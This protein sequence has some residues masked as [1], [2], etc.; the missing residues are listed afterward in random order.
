[1]FRAI[2]ED[3][4]L[5]VCENCTSFGKIIGTVENK[6]TPVEKHLEA[7]EK[8]QIIIKNYAEIIKKKRESLNLTQEEFAKRISEKESLVH[9]IESGSL[10]PSLELAK[11]IERFL[12]IKLIEEYEE[13][14]EKRKSV[15]FE[16]FT[17]GDFIKTKHK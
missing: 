16:T 8:T 9:K 1:M 10:E 13:Q 14:Q 3:V 5:N 6:Q 15:N 12:K 17:L 11:K 7:T 4:E 2:V